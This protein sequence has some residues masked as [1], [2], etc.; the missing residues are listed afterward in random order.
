MAERR[1][2]VV[3]WGAVPAMQLL[4]AGRYAGRMCSQGPV[5]PVVTA[6]QDPSRATAVSQER[7]ASRLRA[8]AG[9][10]SPA[11]TLHVTRGWTEPQPLYHAHGR[12]GPKA[13]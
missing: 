12:A 8:G 7:D 4:S 5:A 3:T 2:G 13:F 1:C 9:E 10:R 6:W 11:F